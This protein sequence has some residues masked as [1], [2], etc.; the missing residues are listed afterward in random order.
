MFLKYRTFLLQ[1]HA[2]LFKIK[3][4]KLSN[5]LTKISYVSKYAVLSCLV[6]RKKTVK[7]HKCR[8]LRLNNYTLSRKKRPFLL[9]WVIWLQIYKCKNKYLYNEMHVDLFFFFFSFYWVLNTNKV[10]L[11]CSSDRKKIKIIL[12]FKKISC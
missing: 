1:W 8:I 3:L 11:T 2:W 10:I 4:K 5:L 6:Y 7:Q 12:W 9:P